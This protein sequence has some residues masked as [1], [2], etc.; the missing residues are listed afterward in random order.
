MSGLAAGSYSL[1][2]MATDN[3]NMSTT[4]TSVNITVNTTGPSPTVLLPPTITAPANG[5]LLGGTSATVSWNSVSGAASYLVRCVDLTGT[6]PKDSRNTPNSSTAFLYIDKYVPTSITMN[7]VP[8]HSYNFWIHAASS[9]FPSGGAASASAGTYLSFSVSAT[10]PA[11][12]GS[13]NVAP[14]ADTYSYQFTPTVNYGS[15]TDFNVGGGSTGHTRTAYLRFNVSGLPIGATVTDA[16]LS[17]VCMNPGMGGALRKFIPTTAQWSESGPTWNNP[18]AG[19]DGSGNL[20]TLGL[21]NW[22]STYVFYNLA[23]SVSANGRVTFVIRSGDLDGAGYYSKEHGVLSQRPV[24]RI[25]YT[26]IPV[27]NG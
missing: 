4:S 5:A 25:A 21:V 17:L 1:T 16:R 8:G 26:T 22:N 15:A 2:A 20:W 13:F 18:L 10:W 14:E 7:V 11:G 19:V 3:G 27:G 6:T 12:S 9:T 23:S 24:L